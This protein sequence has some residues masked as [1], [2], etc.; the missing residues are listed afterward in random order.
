MPTQNFGMPL[1]QMMQWAAAAKSQ[2]AAICPS[3]GAGKAGYLE[4]HQ[5]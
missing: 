3:F 4:N 2:A 5:N 1:R